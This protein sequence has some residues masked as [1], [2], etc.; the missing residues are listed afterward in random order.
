MHPLKS[1]IIQNRLH[2]Q[3]AAHEL[4][5]RKPRHQFP[6]S[7]RSQFHRLPLAKF[8]AKK[9]SATA[10]RVPVRRVEANQIHHIRQAQAAQREKRNARR[11]LSKGSHQQKVSNFDWEKNP[12]GLQHSFQLRISR[13]DQKARVTPERRKEGQNFI[14]QGCRCREDEVNAPRGASEAIESSRRRNRSQE[15]ED[16]TL[17]GSRAVDCILVRSFYSC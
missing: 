1:F 11:L 3:Q 15:V 8:P 10:L 9:Q 7:E 13:I 17:P 5:T 6:W 2:P 16:L 4:L 12:R 14:R